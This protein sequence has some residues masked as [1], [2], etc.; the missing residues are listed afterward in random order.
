MSSL[1]KNYDSGDKTNPWS[2]VQQRFDKVEITLP[3]NIAFDLI[4]HAFSIKPA[5]KA[6]WAQMVEDL[7]SM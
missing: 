4:S 3:D 6:Q 1:A 7:N 5:A 2:V